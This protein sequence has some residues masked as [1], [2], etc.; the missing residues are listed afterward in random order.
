[1]ELTPLP[2]VSP[3][4]RPPPTPRADGGSEVVTVRALE[5]VVHVLCVERQTNDVEDIIAAIT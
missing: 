5:A 2:A 4:A 1:M 3:G